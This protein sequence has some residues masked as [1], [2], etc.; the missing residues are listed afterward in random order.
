M[1]YVIVNSSG[2]TEIREDSHPLQE[3]AFVLTDTQHDQLL[4][5]EY[6]FQNGQIVVNP[7]PY[8]GTRNIS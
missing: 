8:T 2:T 4:S 5:G 6:I 3:G 7:N 1:K